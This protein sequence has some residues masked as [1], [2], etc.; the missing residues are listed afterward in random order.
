MPPHDLAWQ[1]MRPI[2]FSREATWQGKIN[3]LL[4][5]DGKPQRHRQPV[6]STFQSPA[7]A[8]TPAS[9]FL[10]KGSPRYGSTL[11]PP[12]PTATSRQQLVYSPPRVRHCTGLE[13]LDLTGTSRHL[14]FDQ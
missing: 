8:D 12:T 4:Y 5:G 1:V 2:S 7:P 14:P 6:R 13:S 9:W 11:T 10:T 3:P